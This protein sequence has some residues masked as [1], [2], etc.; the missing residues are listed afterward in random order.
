MLSLDLESSFGFQNEQMHLQWEMLMR[1]VWHHL[2][3]L[4]QYEPRISLVKF[5]DLHGRDLD[6]N[7]PLEELQV[8][9]SRPPCEPLKA[10]KDLSGLSDF[11]AQTDPDAE[12]RLFKCDLI[13]PEAQ[14]QGGDLIARVYRGGNP[15]PAISIHQNKL[16]GGGA[17]STWEFGKVHYACRSEDGLQEYHFT[18]ILFVWASFSLKQ[19]APG[20]AVDQE[21]WIFMSRDKLIEMYGPLIPARIRE[22]YGAKETVNQLCVSI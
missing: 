14:G 20:C 17:M 22:T 2:D 11:S 16:R 12:G 3:E 10:P 4:N 15:H 5:Y 1:Q 9:V 21:N 6:G 19:N 7:L 8:D 13:V 18:P